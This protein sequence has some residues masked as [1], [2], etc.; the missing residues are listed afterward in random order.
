MIFARPIQSFAFSTGLSTLFARS[1]RAYRVIMFHGVG[2]VHMPVEAFEANLRWMAERF[3][4]VSLSDVVQGIEQ[5]RTPDARGEVALT[6]DDGLANHFERAYPVLKRLGLPASFF[7]CPDLIDGRRWI[8]NQEARARLRRMKPEAV[9]EF[10]Q[11][12]L[13]MRTDAIERVVQRMKQLPLADRGRAEAALRERTP[14][15]VPTPQEHE[16]YDPISWEQVRQLDPSLI[17]IGSHTLSHPILP[18]IDDA[19]LEHEVHESRRVLEERLGRP[20]D[21]F[22]YP[23]GS[24]DD[25]VYAKVSRSYRAAITTNYGLAQPSSDV[26]R[27]MRIPATPNLAL[28]AW[29]MHWPNA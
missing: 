2:D 23:N 6:F 21:L 15:F 29:R 11:A 25:R 28:M 13:G 20:V 22:C 24:H 14:E 5:G 19:D 16:H 10:A 26:H 12:A 17:T 4:M 1:R 27:L 3:R 18:T 9:R 8:W 7:I